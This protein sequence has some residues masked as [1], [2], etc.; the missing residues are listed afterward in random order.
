[1]GTRENNNKKI[2][3]LA[4]ALL[5][6]GTTV[7]PAKAV[8]P[9]ELEGSAWYPGYA[10]DESEQTFINSYRMW[11][12]GEPAGSYSH[13]VSWDFSEAAGDV[14]LCQDGNGNGVVAA[15]GDVGVRDHCDLESLRTS[16]DLTESRVLEAQL[17]LPPCE[18]EGAEQGLCIEEVQIFEA[19]SSPVVATLDVTRPQSPGPVV[20]AQSDIGLLPGS[21]TSIWNSTW[22]HAGGSSTYLV[23]ASVTGTAFEV[24][25]Q[26]TFVYS[27]LQIAVTPVEEVESIYFGEVTLSTSG[28]SLS[29]I[30]N[31]PE[32][33]AYTAGTSGV[34]GKC[35]RNHN[36]APNTSVAVSVRVPDTVGGFFKGRMESPSV[37]VAP[38]EGQAGT[39]LISVSGKSAEIPR[40]LT[41]V[42]YC[43]VNGDADLDPTTP[44]ADQGAISTE[45]TNLPEQLY[46]RA[47]FEAAPG[48]GTLYK[49]TEI[50]WNTLDFIE[51]AKIKNSDTATSVQTLWTFS[52]MGSFSQ[53]ECLADPTIMHGIVTTNAMAYS[54]APPTLDSSGS[55]NYVVAGM[56]WMPGG[57]DAVQGSY[58]LLLNRA[59]A[60]CLYGELGDNPTASVTIVDDQAQEKSANLTFEIDTEWVRLSAL[61]FEFSTNTISVNIQPETVDSPSVIGSPGVTSVTTPPAP[62]S[63]P[64]IPAAESGVV[65]IGGV[66]STVSIAPSTSGGALE[67]SGEDWSLSVSPSTAGTALNA[68]GELELNPQ[69]TTDVSGSGFQPD[70][71]ASAYLI[72]SGTTTAA[73]LGVTQAALRALTTETIDLGPIAVNSTGSFT[74]NLDLSTATAGDY[75]LQINGAAPDGTIRSINLKASVMDL[76]LKGWTKKISENQVKVYVKNV[77]RAG[78][79][80]IFVNGEEIAWINAGDE[81]DHKLRFA[82]GFNYLVRTVTLEPGKNR[83]EIRLDGERIRFNTYSLN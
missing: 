37:S 66:A 49:D 33:C 15:S 83:I 48:S 80:Q 34:D 19:G 76:A 14:A 59:T 6:V 13:L 36:F 1:M 74:A 11:L 20:A 22:T 67:I 35:G 68:E 65:L 82:Q 32:K 16:D 47:Q 50:D 63:P 12:L 64:A 23:N 58:N 21:T 60:D 40:V 69:L 79:V 62:G 75:I 44:C 7:G 9:V 24:D 42:K 29:E 25:G 26:E 2:L 5:L 71:K 28:G 38:V 45:I 54:D 81:T 27:D 51:W 56:H 8:A 10:Q 61:G 17:V 52:T 30:N 70:S 4:A 46:S 43:D 39:Q 78:K 31:F 72:P 18:V 77:V 41:S 73:G 53:L 3:G 57:I 55:L